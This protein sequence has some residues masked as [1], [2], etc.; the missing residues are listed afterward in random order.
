M[1]QLICA[2]LRVSVVLSRLFVAPMASLPALIPQIPFLSVLFRTPYFNR[3]IPPLLAHLV[4]RHFRNSRV[5]RQIISESGSG[6]CQDAALAAHAISSRAQ[7][8][9]IQYAPPFAKAINGRH[10]NTGK[11]FTC[12]HKPLTSDYLSIQTFLFRR[13]Y[14]N[15]QFQ[16][17]CAIAM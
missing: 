3:P 9:V 11:L 16:R 15:A 2:A 12:I 13:S 6:T 5:L 10:K 14:S 1:V 17:F 7:L 4:G 8:A